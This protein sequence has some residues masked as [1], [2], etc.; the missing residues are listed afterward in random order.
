MGAV[1]VLFFN[2][3]IGYKGMF[4]LWLHIEPHTYDF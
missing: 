1:H 3:A 2:L 4:I